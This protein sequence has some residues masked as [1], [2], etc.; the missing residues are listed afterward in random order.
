MNNYEFEVRAEAEERTL[1]GVAVPY[2]ETISVG[3]IEE[4]FERGSIPSVDGVKLFYG[5]NHLFAKGFSSILLKPCVS[6]VDD[7]FRTFAL[8][9][10]YLTLLSEKPFLVTNLKLFP[11]S[12]IVFSN[13]EI[14]GANKSGK[15]IP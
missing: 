15:N 11:S 5:H 6:C 12:A 7:I 14:K 1:K 13:W 4:R 2:N 9:G 10:K 3:G 8:K